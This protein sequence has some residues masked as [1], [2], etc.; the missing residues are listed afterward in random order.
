MT[1]RIVNCATCIFGEVIRPGL[2][3]AGNSAKIDVWFFFFFEFKFG[4]M[5]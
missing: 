3:D 2:A 4:D 5:S 1:A